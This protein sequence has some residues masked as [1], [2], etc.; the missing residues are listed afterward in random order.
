MN[1]RER[2]MPPE[3]AARLMTAIDPDAWF[4]PVRL[5]YESRR[6]FRRVRDLIRKDRFGEVIFAVERPN[7]RFIAVTSAE[8][9][10][11]IYRVP[12]GGIAYGEDIVSAVHRE[13]KEE[14]GL[15]V[16][17]VRL[18]GVLAFELTNGEDSVPFYSFLFHLR[19]IGGRLLEDA[20]EDEVSG[21][22]EAD[23]AGLVAIGENL[24]RISQSWRDWG[25]F[26]RE[27]TMAAAEYVRT[28]AVRG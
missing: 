12:T 26:R 7:G 8:Y 4:R 1:R 19:E 11:G 15:E 21:V 10:A 2:Y 22:L 13:V 9:P 5:E 28:L 25:R 16:E 6:F 24:G 27:T 3:Q 17:R 20:T 23:A 18:V 14:L